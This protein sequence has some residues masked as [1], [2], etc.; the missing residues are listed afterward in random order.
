MRKM[1]E[2][3]YIWGESEWCFKSQSSHNFGHRK[4][5]L[6]ELTGN[7]SK[8]CTSGQFLW[9]FMLFVHFKAEW[10]IFLQKTQRIGQFQKVK[11]VSPSKSFK[12]KKNQH[13]CKGFQK[14]KN[15]QP[16][17]GRGGN[18][19]SSAITCFLLLLFVY[20]SCAEGE[21]FSNQPIFQ[22]KHSFAAPFYFAM[23]SSIPFWDYGGYAIATENVWEFCLFFPKKRP[24]FL[25][26]TKNNSSFV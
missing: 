23:G 9:L 17:R 4:R 13:K 2:I 10:H 3:C 25:K 24:F 11:H 6:Q 7:L 20:L 1:L 14:M 26:I 19:L 22:P 21:Q 18:L 15:T 5:L 12:Q 8:W 16:Q